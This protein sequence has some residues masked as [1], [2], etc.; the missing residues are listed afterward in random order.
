MNQHYFDVPFAFSGDKTAIPDP[1]QVGGSVSFTEGWNYNYQR[2]LS[3]DPAALPIDRSTTNW[4]FEQVTQAIQAIQQAGVPEFILASQNAGTA[5][6]YGQGAVVLWSASGNAPF[7]KYVSLTAANTNTPSAADPQGLTTGWQIEVDPIATAAQAAAGTNDASIMTPL[8]VAQQT[9]LRALLAGSSSQVFNVGPATTAT[10]ALQLQ[11]AQ[12][13]AG[14]VAGFQGYSTTPQ[15]L[16]SALANYTVQYT[17][18]AVGTFNLPAGSTMPL[19]STLTFLNDSAFTLTIA[20]AGSD[21]I[22]GTGAYT[23]IVMQPGDRLELQSRGSTDWHIIGGSAEF[24]FNPVVVAGATAPTHATQLQQIGHGQC[25]FSWGSSTSALLSPHNGQNLIINGVPQQIPAAGVSISNSG[26][27]ANTFYLVYAF[28]NSG[29]MTLEAVTTGHVTASNGIE[30]KSGDATRTLVGAIL[31][32]PTA[33]FSTTNNLYSVIT[34]FNRR[35]I[36]LQP[37]AS[38]A[39]ITTNVAQELNTNARCTFATWGDECVIVTA[40]CYVSNN[41]SSSAEVF[42]IGV[43]A[44][45]VYSGLA[46]NGNIA[47]SGAAVTLSANVTPTLSQGGHFATCVGQSGSGT[48]NFNQIISVV[49]RG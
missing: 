1:L 4:L 37:V 24:Q 42:G 22:Y 45:N 29:V 21:S 35:N 43:D 2:N 23:S 16:T 48:S 14:S 18:A 46:A 20:R 12:A 33:T 25:V 26:L 34:W 8:K 17:G 47:F 7:G 39:T 40:T 3:T 10:Q 13:A 9:A 5:F 32:S 30:I 27:A 6:S 31:T 19:Q 36:S 28:M 41:T 44:A 11:Q 38:L 49:L 15:T